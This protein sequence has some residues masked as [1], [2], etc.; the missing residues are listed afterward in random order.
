M[1][2]FPAIDLYKGKAV[3]LSKGDYAQLTVYSD[4]PC[5]VAEYFRNEG[6]EQLHVVDLEGARS[7]GTPNIETVE[8]IVD[9]FGGFTELGGGVR[10]AE[11]IEKYL[12]AGVSR[13]ILGTAAATD[14]AFLREAIAKFGDK[15]AVGADLKNG[16]VAVKGWTE[17]SGVTCDEFFAMLDLIGVD[18][19]ICT[20]VSKDGMLSGTNLPL[21]RHLSDTYSVKL[22]ASGGVTTESDIEKLCELGIDGAILGKAIYEGRLK[23]SDA[24]KLAKGCRAK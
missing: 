15:V 5:K 3:R 20:D 23:V 6:A 9:A 10:S 12:K 16:E 21:Y 14:G 1:R 24:V 18:T 2:I 8:R 13:V 22:I 7:G 17:S 11:V 19:V 4:K